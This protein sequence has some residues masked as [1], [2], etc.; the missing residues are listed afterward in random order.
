M[1]DVNRGVRRVDGRGGA[2]A[3]DRAAGRTARAG[4]VGAMSGS[5][6]IR[7]LGALFASL[8]LLGGAAVEGWS[9][10]P[11]PEAAPYHARCRDA[12]S[13]FPRNIGDW[14][15]QDVAQPPQ[16]VALLR[17]NILLTRSFSHMVS[18]RRVN[19]LFV[20]CRDVRDIVSH[21]PP[22][23]YPVTRGMEQVAGR[24]RDW[25]VDGL[26]FQATEYEFRSGQFGPAE[27]LI[28]Q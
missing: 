10:G 14:S 9:L 3:L 17:P 24:V 7:N 21:Y 12:A 20:Q 6:S 4:G 23:C 13:M 27:S 11:P 18:G 22:I 2:S 1:G 25:D 16:A 19:V 26:K 8:C 5:K 15:G 28:V